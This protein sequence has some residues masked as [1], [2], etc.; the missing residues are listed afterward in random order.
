MFQSE[1]ELEEAL[2]TPTPEVV[3]TLFRR[4]GDLLV[5]GVAGKMGPSLARMARRAFDLAGQ[6]H[7]RVIGVARFSA[8]TE[9]TLQAQGIET[10][11]ADLLHDP[12]LARL[13]D[14]PLV[15]FLAGRK[16]GSTGDEPTTWAQNVLVPALVARRFRHSR[17]VALSTGNVYGL[18][19]VEGRGAV[20][21]DPPEPVGEYAQSCLGRERMF[22]HASAAYGT[23]VAL[24]RL[25]Y[26]CDLRYGVLVDIAQQILAGQPVDVGMS[27][28]NT[29]W[30]GDANAMILRAFDHAA[31]PA[32]YVNVTGPETLFV[33]E[34]AAEMARRFGRPVHFTGTEAP[35]ALLS[36][37]DRARELW[38]P[39]RVSAETLITWVVDWLQ[40]GGRTLRKP[41]HFS[42]RDGRF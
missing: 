39:P 1:D 2:S 8:G 32:W 24:I 20:E 19:S 30:Q 21:T 9:R 38:G 34:V 11:R 7:R 26:A 25:N 13:P 35:T 10:L 29:I 18:T 42:V 4:D 31:S 6:P 36:N 27:A 14:T 15:L 40:R 5:L 23:A 33:R 17:I 41:T 16:F 37:T 28:F 22:Q 12:D 3:E